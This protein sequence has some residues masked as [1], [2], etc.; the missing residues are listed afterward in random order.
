MSAVAEEHSK[1]TSVTV[2]RRVAA[3]Q[4][5]DDMKS[6]LERLDTDAELIAADM[7]L[8][9]KLLPRNAYIGAPGTYARHVYNVLREVAGR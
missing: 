9:D 5:R 4:H 6:A 7:Q 3:R 2:H 1:A 8:A